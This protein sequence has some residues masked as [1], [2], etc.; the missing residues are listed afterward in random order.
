[1]SDNHIPGDVMRRWS[2][3]DKRQMRDDIRA[4][5]NTPEGR[6]LLMALIGI[7]GVYAPVGACGGSPA[8]MAYRVGRRDAAADALSLCNSSARELVQK[9]A[10]ER[11]ALM[12]RRERDALTKKG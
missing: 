5:L 4:V 9:A 6:R 12:T 1:M 8:E 2:E 11:S 3:D 10:E 7:S